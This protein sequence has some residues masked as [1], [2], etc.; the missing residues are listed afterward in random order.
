[1]PAS[2]RAGLCSRRRELA[3]APPTCRLHLNCCTH[4]ACSPEPRAAAAGAGPLP[5]H[6][7]LVLA[8][9]HRA[10]VVAPN[11]WR[12]LQRQL[13]QRLMMQ[14]PHQYQCSIVAS[15]A[16]AAA[17][18]HPLNIL[19]QACQVG[20][21]AWSATVGNHNGQ[22]HANSACTFTLVACVNTHAHTPSL[23]TAEAAAPSF[24]LQAPSGLSSDEEGEGEVD[25]GAAAARRR[26]RCE[27]A[28][29]ELR[30][31]AVPRPDALLLRCCSA[32]LSQSF[33]HGCPARQSC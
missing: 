6:S 25:S 12:Q 21:H 33:C 29:G 14:T 3:A 20:S 31:A 23:P 10:A 27:Q 24:S 13:W 26:R 8:A 5:R 22:Q 2:R 32:M 30:A 15:A 11:R 19:S 1:M 18:Q 7:A 9:V 16:A 28:Q 4:Q 17:C